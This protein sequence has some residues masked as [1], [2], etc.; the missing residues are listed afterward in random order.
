MHLFNLC[1]RAQTSEQN[2]KWE[3]SNVQQQQII[4][5]VHIVIS[6]CLPQAKHYTF[7]SCKEEEDEAI[8]HWDLSLVVITSNCWV[9]TAPQAARLN[10]FWLYTNDWLCICPCREQNGREHYEKSRQLLFATI[11]RAILI[12][13]VF[14]KYFHEDVFSLH[15][16]MNKEVLSY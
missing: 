1:C 6:I 12:S 9:I 8:L 2:T 16:A 10:V 4:L 7:Q 13:S 3:V 5:M 15:M 14:L 11:K